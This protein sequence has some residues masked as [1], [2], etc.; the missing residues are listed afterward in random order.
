MEK[1][2]S[3]SRVFIKNCDTCH[4]V[5]LLI[6]RQVN[7]MHTDAGDLAGSRARHGCAFASAPSLWAVPG[8][9]PT[10]CPGAAAVRKILPVSL[11]VNLPSV[12]PQ[13]FNVQ[14]QPSNPTH[15]HS[16]CHGQ[17]QWQ[18]VGASRKGSHSHSYLV[19]WLPRIRLSLLRFI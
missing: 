8:L 6:E 5:F 18:S 2:C 19:S 11:V 17:G 16:L 10:E 1:S 9:Y 13:P 15:A 14:L 4:T 3:C 7:E 12:L